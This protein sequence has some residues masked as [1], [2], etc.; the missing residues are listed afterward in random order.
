MWMYE[1]VALKPTA[2]WASLTQAASCVKKRKENEK[3]KTAQNLIA[4]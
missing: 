4:Q 3:N 1:N 2:L